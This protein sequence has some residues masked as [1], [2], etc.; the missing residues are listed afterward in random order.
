MAG[1]GPGSWDR[2]GGFGCAVVGQAQKEEKNFVA[3]ADP[4]TRPYGFTSC[5]APKGTH[6]SGGMVSDARMGAIL[7]TVARDRT[8]GAHSIRRVSA[9]TVVEDA[10]WV[11]RRRKLRRDDMDNFIFKGVN[12]CP[13]HLSCLC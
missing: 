9:T 11:L 12:L 6:G 10:L 7:Q 4:L 2:H 3:I 1:T 5:S 13:N 8:H